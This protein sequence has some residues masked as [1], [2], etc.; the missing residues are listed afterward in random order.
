M[1]W[2]IRRSELIHIWDEI[3]RDERKTFVQI[4]TGSEANATKWH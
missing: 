2:D 4:D 1:I 3:F